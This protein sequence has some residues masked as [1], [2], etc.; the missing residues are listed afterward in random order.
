MITPHVSS[1]DKMLKRLLA[2]LRPQRELTAEDLAV[3]E[4]AERLRQQKTTIRAAAHDAPPGFK[5][6][7]HSLGGR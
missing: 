1:D 6:D 7:K 3:L 2:F 4:E 5:G